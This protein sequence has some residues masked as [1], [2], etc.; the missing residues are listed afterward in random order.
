[1]PP[2]R[3]VSIFQESLFAKQLVVLATFPE[4]EA[5][6]LTD[7][8]FIFAFELFSNTIYDNKIVSFMFQ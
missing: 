4:R 3:H 1:M 6:F 8:S 2:R 5:T 7:L